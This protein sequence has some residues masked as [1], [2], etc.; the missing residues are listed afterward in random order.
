M[1]AV[2]DEGFG[3]FTETRVAVTAHRAAVLGIEFLFDPGD[4]L[5]RGDGRTPLVEVPVADTTTALAPLPHSGRREPCR[6]DEPLNLPDRPVR[7]SVP[8]LHEVRRS[9]SRPC[10]HDECVGGDLGNYLSVGRHR[11]SDPR[12]VVPLAG[13]LPDRTADPAQWVPRRWPWVPTAVGT[14]VGTKRP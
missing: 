12:Q 8:P 4:N 3:D 9:T 2:L 5:S 11:T 1:G 6:S 7:A 14:T 13:R 10:L